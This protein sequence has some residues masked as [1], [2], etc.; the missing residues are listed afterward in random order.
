MYVPLV[1]STLVEP[2]VFKLYVVF[3]NKKKHRFKHVSDEI[4]G[5]CNFRANP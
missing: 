2:M 5:E 4:R 3:E 1:E